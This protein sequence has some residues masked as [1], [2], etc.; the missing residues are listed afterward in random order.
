MKPYQREEKK[1]EEYFAQKP[2]VSQNKEDKMV[3]E[4]DYF[5]QKPFVSQQK[6]D[7]MVSEDD[8]CLSTYVRTHQSAKQ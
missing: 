4:D 1:K 6:E 8:F 2:F 5:A 7:K 3:S